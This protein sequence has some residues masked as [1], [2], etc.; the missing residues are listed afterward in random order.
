MSM[1][2][3]PEKRAG[4]ELAAGLVSLE[5]AIMNPLVPGELVAWLRSVQQA[6]TV[7]RPLLHER[8]EQ[9][10]QKM[11]QEIVRQDIELASRVEQ[12]REEAAAILSQFAGWEA[13]VKEFAE[14]A[15]DVEPREEK[16][17]SHLQGI[18]Q[19]GIDF[20]VATR[21]QE[22]AIHTWHGEAFLR[23]RGGNG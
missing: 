11:L 20:I 3:E 14:V 10:H 8:I 17:Q 18:V 4:D 21:K 15:A 5:R 2:S 13:S 6:A 1:S 19:S 23:D 12:M 16:F 9:D 22:A 7:V